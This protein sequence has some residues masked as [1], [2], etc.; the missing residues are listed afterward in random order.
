[1]QLAST[2]TSDRWDRST[3]WARRRLKKHGWEG[4]KECWQAVEKGL[5]IADCKTASQRGG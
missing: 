3:T 2:S 4:E 5:T 1:V